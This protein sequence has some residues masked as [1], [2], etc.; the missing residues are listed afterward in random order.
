ME[1]DSATMMAFE[2]TNM[3][4]SQKDSVDDGL[5]AHTLDFKSGYAKE[6]DDTSG[7]SSC[8]T[9]ESDATCIVGMGRCSQL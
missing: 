8:T 3:V 9:M 6:S 7:P 1:Y 4:E 5:L 2:P